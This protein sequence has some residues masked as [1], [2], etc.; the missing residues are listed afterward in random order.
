[1]AYSVPAEPKCDTLQNRYI[2][3]TLLSLTVPKHSLDAAH[4]QSS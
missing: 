1:M 4:Q 2:T 3:F